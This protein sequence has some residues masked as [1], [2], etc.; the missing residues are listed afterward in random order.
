MWEGAETHKSSSLSSTI[1][2]YIGL[3]LW[4]ARSNY[5]TFAKEK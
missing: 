2:L 5:Q 1:C 4:L 3:F